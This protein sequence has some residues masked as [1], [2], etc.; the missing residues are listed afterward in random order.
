MSKTFYFKFFLLACIVLPLRVISD[1]GKYVLGERKIHSWSLVGVLL[2]LPLWR[3]VLAK[4]EKKFK[5]MTVQLNKSNRG[6]AFKTICVVL[7]LIL[8]ISAL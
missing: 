3:S 7:G 8:L 6:L 4:G 2:W 1:L 5:A